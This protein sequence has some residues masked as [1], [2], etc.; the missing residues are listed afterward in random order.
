MAMKSFGREPIDL[1]SVRLQRG[2]VYIIP[3]RCKG[4]GI[5]IEFCPLQ[6][7]SESIRANSKGYHLPE[8]APDKEEACIHCQFCSLVCPEFAIYTL[9]TPH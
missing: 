7:L 3:S 5:C 2:Q 8:V 6:V 4:C 1:Q 9:E